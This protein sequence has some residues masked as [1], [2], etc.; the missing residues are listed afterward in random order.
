MTSWLFYGF[1]AFAVAFAYLVILLRNPIHSGL[2]LIGSF[3]CVSGLFV[4]MHAPF[5]GVI[6]ILI[7]TGAI[8]VLFLY[9]MMLLNLKEQQKE[10]RLWQTVARYVALLLIPLG[11]MFSLKVLNFQR[12][13]SRSLPEDFGSVHSVGQQLLGSYVLIFEVSSV[14]LLVAMIGVVVLTQK[15]SMEN[16]R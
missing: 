4:L 12:L 16:P 8:L 10:D 11:W 3:F 9:V 15:K 2:A 13:V 5:L 6:Q 7:Y 14:V 1:S